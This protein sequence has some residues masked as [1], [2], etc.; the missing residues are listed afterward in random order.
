MTYLITLTFKFVIFIFYNTIHWRLV[1]DTISSSK[2]ER[3]KSNMGN[4]SV[5]KTLRREALFE[6]SEISQTDL[7]FYNSLDNYITRY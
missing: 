2:L 7:T 3:P 4:R 6:S 1:G 5:M